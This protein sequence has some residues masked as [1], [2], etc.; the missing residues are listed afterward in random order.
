MIA[1][2]GATSAVFP[3]HANAHEWLR[4]QQRED[5]FA[6][7]APDEGCEYDDGLEIDLHELV[8]LVAKP[9]SPDNVVTAEELAGGLRGQGTCNPHRGRAAALPAHARLGVRR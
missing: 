7:M 3:P 1:E 4:H 8:P 6:E 2:L 9:Q 5:D